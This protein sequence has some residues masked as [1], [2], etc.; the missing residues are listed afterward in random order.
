MVVRVLAD[1]VGGNL[2]MTGADSVTLMVRLAG[3]VPR[4]FVTEITKE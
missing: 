1:I 4:M 2:S 3:A